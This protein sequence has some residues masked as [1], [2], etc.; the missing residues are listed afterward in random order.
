[1]KHVFLEQGVGECFEEILN[2]MGAAIHV[3]SQQF[4]GIATQLGNT[5]AEH[6]LRRHVWDQRGIEGLVG[7]IGQCV[8]MAGY[9]FMSHDCHLVSADPSHALYELKT[10]Y[11][12]WH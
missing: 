6:R 8:Q 4:L 2:D 1:M 12:P 9:H 7:G 10:N 5:D 11:S 3:R